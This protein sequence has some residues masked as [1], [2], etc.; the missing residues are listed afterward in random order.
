MDK[1]AVALFIDE[2][3]YLLNKIGNKYK[4]S[5]ERYNLGYQASC[6]SLKAK[7]AFTTCKMIQIWAA[8]VSLK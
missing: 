7:K 3:C 6:L 8:I 5:T 1:N 4:V 2:G